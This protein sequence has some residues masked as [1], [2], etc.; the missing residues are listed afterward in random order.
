[1]C[2]GIHVT[3]FKRNIEGFLIKMVKLGP[4]EWRQDAIYKGV[5][6]NKKK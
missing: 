5:K 6:I 3:P 1:M 2:V 4:K